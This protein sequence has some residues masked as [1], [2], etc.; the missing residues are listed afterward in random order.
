MSNASCVQEISSLTDKAGAGGVWSVAFNS[1]AMKVASA[2]VDAC[3]NIY[4]F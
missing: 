2:G 1:D 4:G 3:I